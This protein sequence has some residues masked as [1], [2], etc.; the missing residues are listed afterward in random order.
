MKRLIEALG[1]ASLIG[2]TLTTV[3]LAVISRGA[4]I[5]FYEPCLMVLII[6][7]VVGLFGIIVGISRIKVLT[8]AMAPKTA[9]K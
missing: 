3:I 2:F 1:L 7:V 4:L 6:E 5:Y 9:R 8:D